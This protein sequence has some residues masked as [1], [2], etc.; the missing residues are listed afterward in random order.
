MVTRVVDKASE[1][2]LFNF[3]DSYGLYDDTLLLV[4]QSTDSTVIWT[5]VGNDGVFVDVNPASF[6]FGYEFYLGAG[7]D[8]LK[9]SSLADSYYDQSGNDI[10][11]MGAGNDTVFGG[12]GNDTINGGAGNDT[13]NF[14]MLAGDTYHPTFNPGISLGAQDV[15][16]NL[17]L[18]GP[19]DT[20]GFGTD[21]YTGFENVAGGSGDDVFHGNSSA[22]RLYGNEGADYLR[23]REGNDLLV[24]GWGGDTLIGDAGADKIFTYDQ[25]STSG[26]SFQDVVKFTHISDSTSTGMDEVF[27]F[28]TF[29]SGGSDKID[30]SLID[31]NLTIA[32]DQSFAFR[33]TGAFISSGGEV[34]Y[35]MM[36]DS[37]FVLVD[38]DA[39]A[40][41]EMMFR[42]DGV[43]GVTAVDF[44]L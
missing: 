21:T 24:G 19:Q 28:E 40:D 37:T 31:A 12:A 4:M 3:Q 10:V 25:S 32:G 1:G 44:I 7:N 20:V 26:D 43:S 41:A 13:L 27:N 22:N 39:D 16:V 30:L 5:G 29:A 8:K 6:G 9:G 11:D 18:T 15:H 23:G 35:F 42:L 2:D 17:A 36:G 38:N 14:R 33:G 34:R